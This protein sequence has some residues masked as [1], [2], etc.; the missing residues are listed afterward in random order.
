MRITSAGNIEVKTTNGELNFDSGNG[1]I[2]TTTGSTSL[3]FGVNSSEKMRIHSSGNVGIGT[4]N[5]TSFNSNADNLV[6]NESG[7]FTGITLAADNDQG[8]NIYFADPDDDNVGGITYNHTDNYMNFRVNGAERA[9]ITSVGD[10]GIG[11]SSPS[12]YNSRAQ[13]LVIKKTGSDVGISIVAEASSGTDYSSSVLFADGTGGTAGY[14]GSIE[15]DHATDHIAIAT[16]AS[17]RMRIDSSGSVSIGTTTTQAQLE[18]NKASDGSTS[19]PQ[20]LIQGGASTYGAFH[21]LDS[22]AYHIQTNSASRDIEIIC[23]TGGVN[24]G[25]GDTAFSSNSDENLKENIK[26]LN[27]VIDKIKNYRC[28]E[29]NFKDDK[30]KNKK[31]GFIAQDWQKDF[32]QV[33]NKNKQDVLSIKYTETIP[34]LLKAIQEQQDMIQELKKEIEILKSK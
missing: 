29:Y 3:T 4:T 33:V 26:P 27:N 10:I 11:S 22:N 24:L 23:N 14:R 34:V 5:P 9:R 28:V 15:Y 13:D 31:I 21:F 32:S 25:P 7:D 1:V 18:V 30:N 8:S 16:A 19:A 2:Q 20:F 17:E 12:S 6:I